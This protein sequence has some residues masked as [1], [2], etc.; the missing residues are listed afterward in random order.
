M[1][2]TA[3]R[4]AIIFNQRAHR[5]LRRTGAVP[6]GGS[7]VGLAAPKTREELSSALSRFAAA[8]VEALVVDGGDG[9]VREVMTAAG[10]HFGGV[11][12]LLAIVPSGKTNAFALDLGIPSD[13]TVEDALNAVASRA[14]RWRSPIEIRRLD[15]AVPVLRGFLFGAGAFVRATALAQGVHRLGA[16]S[17]LAVAMS[18]TAALSQTLLAGPAN[19][20]RRGDLV[21]IGIDHGPSLE[22]RLY[23]LVAS[24]LERLPLGLQPFGCGKSGLKLLEVEAPPRRILTAVPAL[25]A[26]WDADWLRRAGYHRN[27][28]ERL[29]ISM[30]G[31]FVLDG[32][33][34]GGGH[35]IVSRG[36][37]I[38]F[39]V[40]SSTDPHG[41][42]RE[43]DGEPS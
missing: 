13:W 5:N 20:W 28:A 8:A 3:P 14:I 7:L 17:G 41:P 22:R 32:E 39:A 23:L 40:P 19:P 38:A 30:A 25:L 42:R 36:D 10:D 12:P 1:P 18:I 43:R 27:Q 15:A 37:A 31:G 21:Q 35:L 2:A 11:T 34:Y 33:S 6:F 16:F 24:T 26:G 29:T 4:T 9:T